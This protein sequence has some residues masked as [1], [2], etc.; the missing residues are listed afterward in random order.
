MELRPTVYTYD[1]PWSWGDVVEP[2]SVHVVETDEATVLFGTG[3]ESTADDLVPI[4][5]EHD[6]DVAIAEHGD[7]DHFGG[8]PFLQ[9]ALDVTVAIPGGDVRFLEENDVTHDV[10][11]EAGETDWGVETIGVPGHTPDNMAYLVEDVL[12]AGDTVAGSDSAFAEAG[13]WPGALAPLADELNFDT[14]QMLES[15]PV[16]LEYDV[17][18]LLTSHGRNVLEDAGAEVERL[19]DALAD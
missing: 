9:E 13:D 4:A 1:L 17:S 12:V 7:V 18:T 16:L 11:L 5:K 6:V 15:I 3:D 8:I 2:L 10:A 19:A 14:E